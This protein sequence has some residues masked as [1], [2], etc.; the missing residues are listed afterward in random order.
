MDTLTSQFQALFSAPASIQAGQS[1]FSVPGSVTLPLPPAGQAGLAVSPGIGLS[2]GAVSV[3]PTTTTAARATVT[4]VSTSAPVSVVAATSHLPFSSMIMSSSVGSP[5][6]TP[7][8]SA[9]HPNYGTPGQVFRPGMWGPQPAVNQPF[10]PPLSAPSSWIADPLTSALRQLTNVV[11]PDM[12]SRT[13]CMVYRP[14]YYSQ[15]LL[16]NVPVKSLDHKKLSFK[17]LVY[18][19]TCVARHILSVGGNVD[20]YLSHL[21]FVF[22]HACDN[23]YIDM[24]YSDYDHHVVDAFLK[25]PGRGFSMA[26]PVAIGYSF[27][28][29]RLVSE[30]NDARFGD[31]KKSKKRAA[32]SSKGDIP[33]GYPESNCYFWN[34]KVCTNQNC[35][36]K[37]ICRLCEGA[38]KAVGCPRDK[39]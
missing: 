21:E 25:S 37:H 36:K 20:A 31:S 17:S 1:P 22:R 32:K 30:N 13:A 15:H 5:I 23:S 38:H 33:D 35:S 9:P 19:M 3:T 4:Q 12:V 39:I 29:A 11:D 24:S 14:E 10:N 16:W 28:L 26:D 2:T 27:H 34:Y 18:G 8:F 7:S 6:M